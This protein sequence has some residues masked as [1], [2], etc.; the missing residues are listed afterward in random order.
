M[1]SRRHAC[2]LQLAL[3]SCCATEPTDLMG[4]SIPLALR[5]AV[6]QALGW[7]R[8]ITQQLVDHRLAGGHQ[9]GV[10][11]GRLCIGHCCRALHCILR[12]NGLPKGLRSSTL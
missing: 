3:A 10:R 8:N 2:S 9:V 7:K 5:R 12:E 4:F 11:L 6:D 1:R